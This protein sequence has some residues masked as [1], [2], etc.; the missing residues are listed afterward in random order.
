MKRLNYYTLLAILTVIDMIILVVRDMT[1]PVTS[2]SPDLNFL[3]HNLFLGLTPLL[4][5]WLLSWAVT[6]LSAKVVI[7]FVIIASFLWLIFYPNAPYMITDTIHV[8][9]TTTIRI[10]TQYYQIK[11][12]QL[13]QTGGVTEIHGPVEKISSNIAIYDSLI[14]F[15]FAILSMFYG[16]FSLKIMHRVWTQFFG[17]ALAY[18]GAIISI[19]LSGLGIYIGRMANLRF[20][21]TDIFTEPAVVIKAVLGCL[22]PVSANH[23]TYVM[24]FLFSLIQF[25]II[26]MMRDM[27]KPAASA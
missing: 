8:N 6:K 3:T 14:I 20:N 15:L 9:D 25:S 12:P 27:E 1:M 19:I 13:T 2:G 26:V 24:I 4:V 18:I 10:D 21:S 5:A 17:K 7:L 23:A 22:F 11:N 16:M